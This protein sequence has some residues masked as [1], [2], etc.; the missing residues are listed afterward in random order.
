MVSGRRSI[1]R[2]FKN[3]CCIPLTYQILKQELS[4]SLSSFCFCL[5]SFDL[6]TFW[7]TKVCCKFQS[8]P[9]QNSCILLLLFLL[10]SLLVLHNKLLSSSEFVDI[11]VWGN[12]RTRCLL[13]T[14][15][16]HGDSASDH[17]DEGET[18]T[19]EWRRLEKLRLNTRGWLHAALHGDAYVSPAA[20]LSNMLY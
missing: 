10:C 20:N 7:H 4:T 9:S 3:S 19:V 2:W 13:P 17:D 14:P 5:L 8:S 18:I 1:L 12:V 16:D 11:P 6:K 15:R